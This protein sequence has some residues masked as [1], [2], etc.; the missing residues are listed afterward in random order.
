[1]STTD[2]PIVA[3]LSGNSSDSDIIEE[4]KQLASVLDR[5]VESVL[6]QCPDVAAAALH[7]TTAL[8]M[9]VDMT[10]TK[11]TDY[12]TMPEPGQPVWTL[13]APSRPDVAQAVW[14][15]LTTTIL[16]RDDA[17]TR[18]VIT[19]S[20]LAGVY[21]SNSCKEAKPQLAR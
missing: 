17:K 6:S 7:G 8:G 12:A 4:E 20:L 14:L 18:E 9:L 15:K 19:A 16:G 11:L 3:T 5:A 10:R 13:P 1:M 2:R 21:L